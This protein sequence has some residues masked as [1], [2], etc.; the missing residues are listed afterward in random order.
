MN[1]DL[2]IEV[3]DDGVGFMPGDVPGSS[4]YGLRGMRERAE[5]IGA[6]F[7]VVSQTNI[8]TSIIVRL[9]LVE[10]SKG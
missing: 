8:G 1:G 10:L 7:Q 9:P 4:Q 2:I 6:D 3:R 5:L